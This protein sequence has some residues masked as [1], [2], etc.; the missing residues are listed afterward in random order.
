MKTSKIIFISFFSFVGLFLLSV[1]ILGMAFNGI[2]TEER[3]DR[4][5]E[6]ENR[7]KTIKINKQ[8]K[9]VFVKNKGSITIT[10]GEEQTV[11]YYS[12]NSNDTLIVPEFEIVNDTLFF[13]VRN[14]MSTTLTLNDVNNLK[15]VSGINS[16]VHLSSLDMSSLKLDFKAGKIR[17]N[18][19]VNISNLY[20]SLCENSGFTA[21]PLNVDSLYVNINNSRFRGNYKKRLSLVKGTITNKSD[22]RLPSVLH[23]DLD[24][25]ESSKVRMY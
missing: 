5:V 20:V 25:D 12:Y 6:Y 16:S 3:K 15:S 10:R 21:Y 4:R 19:D 22:V 8:F 2:A 23:I 13:S 9:H 7:V 1:M 18:N 14:G 11:K 24:I 17:I